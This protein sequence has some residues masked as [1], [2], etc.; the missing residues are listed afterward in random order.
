[1]SLDNGDS[2]T[3]RVIYRHVVT[4]Q[5]FFA[6]VREE[7]ELEAR[8]IAVGL[9][10]QYAVKY[11]DDISNWEYVKT[12]YWDSSSSGTPPEPQVIIEE[13]DTPSSS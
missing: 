4:G 6:I 1:V 5:R 3:W 13:G 12:G 11:G 7:T 9:L 2:T 8:S 10:A